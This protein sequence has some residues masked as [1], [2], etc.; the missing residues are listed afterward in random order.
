MKKKIIEGLMK[1]VYM[2]LTG[3]IMWGMYY[4]KGEHDYIPAMFEAILLTIILGAGTWVVFTWWYLHDIQ[5]FTGDRLL[6]RFYKEKYSGFILGGIA[7]FFFTIN[8]GDSLPFLCGVTAAL[9]ASISMDMPANLHDKIQKVMSK[10]APDYDPHAAHGHAHGEPQPFY[11]QDANDEI[12]PRFQQKD[13]QETVSLHWWYL[14]KLIFLLIA[15]ISLSEMI[16]S[17]I[18]YLIKIMHR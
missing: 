15:C 6:M 1:L 11:S 10:P 5:G 7:L 8:S 2:T 3:L 4:V 14:T 12:N 9:I 16:A 13:G 17:L 18:M